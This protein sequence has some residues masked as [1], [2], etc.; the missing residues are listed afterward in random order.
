MCVGPIRAFV[1]R[2]ACVGVS[3][4]LFLSNTYEVGFTRVVLLRVYN[5]VMLRSAEKHTW[6]QPFGLVSLKRRSYRYYVMPMAAAPCLAWF[7]CRYEAGDSIWGRFFDCHSI[8]RFG[9]IP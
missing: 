8:L 2:F 4:A 6:Q 7:G 1:R 3:G 5:I 9:A